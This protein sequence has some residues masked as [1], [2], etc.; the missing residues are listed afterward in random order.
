STRDALQLVHLARALVL[1]GTPLGALLAAVDT[2]LAPGLD[3]HEAAATAVALRYDPTT[4]E[5]EAAGAGHPPPLVVRADGRVEWLEAPGRPVGYPLAG[6][7][8][9]VR[10]RLAAGDVLVVY[11]DGLVEAGR[12]LGRG[13]DALAAQATAARTEPLEGWAGRLVDRVLAADAR[14]DD[15]LVL[16]LR[17]D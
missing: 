3:A 11:T 5:V 14:R 12:D 13:L 1:T 9:T 4:G 8:G 17:R 10:T 16:A 15:V 2:V 7:D 6:S